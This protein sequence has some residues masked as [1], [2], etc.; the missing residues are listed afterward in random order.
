MVFLGLR[1]WFWGAALL[2]FFWLGM[3]VSVQVGEPADG[4]SDDDGLMRGE[5]TA[6]HPLLDTPTGLQAG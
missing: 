6:H 4:F 3:L 2:C 1:R 5:V